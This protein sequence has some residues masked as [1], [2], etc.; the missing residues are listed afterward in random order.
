MKITPQSLEEETK[1][2]II[3]LQNGYWGP[4]A[5]LIHLSHHHELWR[6]DKS[7]FSEWM[8]HLT[9]SYKV[10]RAR[11]WRYKKAASFYN[12]LRIIDPS[13]CDLK[14]IPKSISAEALE[15]LERLEPVVPNDFFTEIKDKV[16]TSTISIRKL[17]DTWAAYKP[18]LQGKTRRG[19][20]ISKELEVK[21]NKLQQF[22]AESLL[23][24]KQDLSWTGHKS[25]FRCQVFQNVRDYYSKVTYD[26]LA[27]SLP[28]QE[29]EVE[30]HAFYLQHSM[31]RINNKPDENYINYRWIIL[32][33]KEYDLN[34][35][36]NF[37][38]YGVI[39]ILNGN[40][41]IRKCA[42]NLVLDQEIEHPFLLDLLK[43]SISK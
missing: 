21:I 15:I 24:I 34:T 12:E 35:D 43:M 2:A 28:T 39:T 40:L 27:I 10:S 9:T 4:I 3:S 5:H 29:S 37:H 20:V 31:G 19:N 22:D 25:P 8:A 6:T 41:T 32:P 13:L 30:I 18:A 17:K 16:L 33:D 42:E 11:C 14:D 7:N 26:R 36:I 1:K 23:A 38:D